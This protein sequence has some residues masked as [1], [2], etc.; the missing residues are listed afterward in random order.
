MDKIAPTEINEQ[1]PATTCYCL[2]I[3]LPSHGITGSEEDEDVAL[4]QFSLS[5]ILMC[6]VTLEITTIVGRV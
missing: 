5:N 6:I 1:C 4:D 2:T 3:D